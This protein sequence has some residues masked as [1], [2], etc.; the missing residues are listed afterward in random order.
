MTEQLL[1]QAN[2]LRNRIKDVSK[3]LE[4]LDLTDPSDVGSK[5][6][7]PIVIHVGMAQTIQF[8]VLPNDPTMPITDIQRLDAR[9]HDMLVKLLI[10]YK[11]QLEDNFK[12]LG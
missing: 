4:Q 9:M 11:K 8:D 1:M 5:R 2:A 12:N 10:E 7:S 3:L 6:I